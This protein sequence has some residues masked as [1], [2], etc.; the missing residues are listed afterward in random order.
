MSTTADLIIAAVEEA[1]RIA[2][3][4]NNVLYEDHWINE[5]I[6]TVATGRPIEG[7]ED[8]EGARLVRI[9]REPHKLPSTLDVINDAP[10]EEGP[11][12]LP[13][14]GLPVN[15]GQA[16]AFCLHDFTWSFYASK[17]DA[18]LPSMPTPAKHK[19]LI[20]AGSLVVEFQFCQS[21]MDR[22]LAA[23]PDIVSEPITR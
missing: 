4:Q 14:E 13:G 23:Y 15:M 12:Y 22:Y 3:R 6:R 1:D 17:P 9:N 21:C 7:N 20:S 16:C 19:V 10:R 18:V 8:Y 2:P 11:V 5:M